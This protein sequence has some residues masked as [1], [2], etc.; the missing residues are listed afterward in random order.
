[1]EGLFNGLVVIDFHG[2]LHR[3]IV[4]LRQSQDLFDDL[5]DNPRA[6]QAAID[7]EMATKPLTY[8]SDQPVIDRPFEEAEYNEA[9]RYPFTHWSESRYS[10]GL[11]GVWYGADSVDTTVYETVH[12]WRFI[13]L[14]DAGWQNVEGVSIERKLYHVRCD[15]ALLDFKSKIKQYPALIDPCAGG[16]HL[17]HQVG[18]RI[19]YDGHPGL[20][21][22]S[23][24]CKGDVY[25]VFN[26]QVLSNPRPV[27][28][29]NYQIKNS[30]VV[31]SR[32]QGEVILEI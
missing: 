13:L 31:I 20:I 21:T 7:L 27:C 14:K 8:L 16:Y 32:Q 1:M 4:S 3:N 22:R 26:R 9:I 10:D 15:A 25:A 28:Y 17:T 12:H 5:S 18:K 29:L 11:F 6:I 19:H 24:R 30:H 23:A 2:D